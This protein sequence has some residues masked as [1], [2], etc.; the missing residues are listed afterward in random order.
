VVGLSSLYVH[1]HCKAFELVIAGCL[2]AW[3]ES[4]PNAQFADES[5]V[6]VFRRKSRNPVVISELNLQIPTAVSSQ[7]T[8]QSKGYK[9]EIVACRAPPH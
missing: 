3:D 4:S 6:P 5:P 7:E 9:D 1:G 8:T 2:C